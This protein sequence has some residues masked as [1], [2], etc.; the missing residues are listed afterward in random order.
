MHELS[1][2]G[3]CFTFESF[4]TLQKAGQLRGARIRYVPRSGACRV[5]D[6]RDRTRTSSREFSGIFDALVVAK[7]AQGDL[8]GVPPDV[9]WPSER[10]R[11]GVITQSSPLGEARHSGM[12]TLDTVR[13]VGYGREQPAVALEHCAKCKTMQGGFHTYTSNLSFVNDGCVLESPTL[14][15]RNACACKQQQHEHPRG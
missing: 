7:S 8:P 15:A 6:D 4:A 1:G 3:T 10:G 9:E 13:F 12:L 2:I 5:V 11:R 14:H